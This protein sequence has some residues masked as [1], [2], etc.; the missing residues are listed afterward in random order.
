MYYRAF[1]LPCQGAQSSGGNESSS[2]SSGTDAGKQLI[3]H[4]DGLPQARAV[5]AADDDHA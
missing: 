2:F 3:H 4:S 1:N 5:I